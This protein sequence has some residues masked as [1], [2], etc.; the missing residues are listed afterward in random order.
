MEQFSGLGTEIISPGAFNMSQA[1]W[2]LRQKM[3]AD[4]G[5]ISMPSTLRAEALLTTGQSVIPLFFGNVNAQ[6]AP[7]NT[8]KR[9]VQNDTFTVM[10]LSLHIGLVNVAG[11]VETP[12][13][14]AQMTL[15]T[16]PNPLVFTAGELEAIYNG[17]LQ[18][19]VDTTRFIDYIPGRDFY[20]VGQSQQGV[21]SSAANNAPTQRDEW[22]FQQW[23][24][25]NLYPTMEL[26]G[27]ATIET[28]H[29]LGASMDLAGDEG[30]N[31]YLVGQLYGFLNTG[32]SSVYTDF[33]KAAKSQFSEFN[34]SPA[35]RVALRR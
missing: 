9:L 29:I 7:F 22:S 26:A 31:L 5:V 18:M 14:H 8:E 4:A 33:L 16:F 27:T 6:R 19:L 28:N 35:S 24:Q 2:G 32:A 1:I 17:G 12:Q 10:G 3:Y 20:R 13:E 34:L 25:R 23:G 30:T 21:G 15:H 11:A